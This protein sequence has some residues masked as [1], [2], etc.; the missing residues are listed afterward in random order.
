MGATLNGTI[1]PNGTDTQVY[2]QYGTTTSYGTTTTPQDIGS[3]TSP[4]PFSSGA[5]TGL[6]PGTTYDYQLVT[7]ANGLTST[8][9]NQ[10]FTTAGSNAPPPSDSDTPAMPP[11]ALSIL[12]LALMGIAA[13]FLKR[14]G[15]NA[16]C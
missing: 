5:L 2:F 7:V 10:T 16:A 6:Q 8:Y 9:A 14:N 12:A 3:G 13:F 15:Q 11:W 4:V 1:N